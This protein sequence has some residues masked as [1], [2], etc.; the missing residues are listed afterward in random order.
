MRKWKPLNLIM[1]TTSSKLE[2]RSRSGNSNEESCDDFLIAHFQKEWKPGARV[3]AR[4]IM[5][6]LEGAHVSAFKYDPITECAPI[7]APGFHSF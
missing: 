1:M 3:S 5:G 2:E 7:L 4:L 6:S